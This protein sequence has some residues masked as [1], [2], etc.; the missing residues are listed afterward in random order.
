MLTQYV[1]GATLTTQSVPLQNE[2]VRVVGIRA[3]S[4]LAVVVRLSGSLVAVGLVPLALVA[5]NVRMDVCRRK[6]TPLGS[7]PLSSSA[8]PM[9]R[10]E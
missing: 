10:R 3:G 7:E 8:C 4:T 1:I 5:P 9:C 2:F 6:P